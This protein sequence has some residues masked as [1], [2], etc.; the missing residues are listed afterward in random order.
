MNKQ[1]YDSC[2]NVKVPLYP[3]MPWRL[4]GFIIIIFLIILANI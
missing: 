1:L 2:K 3:E 4:I